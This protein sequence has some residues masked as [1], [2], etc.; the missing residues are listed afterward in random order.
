MTQ[1]PEKEKFFDPR[2]PFESKRPETHEEWQANGEQPKP[3]ASQ[4]VAGV[5]GPRHCTEMVS[6]SIWKVTS[7]KVIIL[8]TKPAET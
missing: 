3:V 4:G 5:V 8:Y 1:L 7:Q 6:G 2:K